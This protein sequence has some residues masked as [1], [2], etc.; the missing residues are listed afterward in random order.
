MSILDEISAFMETGR[1]DVARFLYSAPARYKTFPI[2]KHNGEDRIIAQPSSTLKM[3]QRFVLDTKLS[4]LPVHEAAAAYVPGKGIRDN[5]SFH[6]R[7]KFI[8]KLDFEKFFPSLTVKDW[9]NYVKENNPKGIDPSDAVHYERLLFWGDGGFTPKILSIGAPTSP[10]VSNVL[11]YNLDVELAKIAQR[12]KIIYTRY[13]DDI[14]FSSDSKQSLLEI[15]EYTQA[16]IRRTRYPKLK[17]NSSKRG[18]YG[19]GQRRVVTGLILTPTNDV[20]IGRDRKRLVSSMINRARHG[21]LDILQLGHLKG[22]LGFAV[23]V[24]P[25]LLTRL[26][27]KYGDGVIDQI[28]KLE[29]PPRVR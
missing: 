25:A 20:S 10:C 8:L 14:T 22:L 5:A 24:E 9:R 2:K 23:A 16:L 18:L 21:E 13:A 11:M 7:S 26:R 6:T 4:M 28:M 3:I 15:E 29:L 17:L 27:A 19:R 12:N 1:T